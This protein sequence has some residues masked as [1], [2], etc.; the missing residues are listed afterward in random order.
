[1]SRWKCITCH[2]VADDIDVSGRG[3]CVEEKDDID[4]FELRHTTVVEWDEELKDR[5]GGKYYEANIKV[6]VFTENKD[7]RHEKLF[8]IINSL[9]KHEHHFIDPMCAHG[10][11][12]KDFRL[13]DKKESKPYRNKRSSYM[14][15]LSPE[16]E[17]NFKKQHIDSG[18][19]RL[20][21]KNVRTDAEVKH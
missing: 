9:A 3:S 10:G 17:K 7:K 2:M 19:Y 5:V 12:N 15:S 11:L 14:N 4:D 18:A 21:G 1:M 20:V 16:D 8:S 6:C 13:L